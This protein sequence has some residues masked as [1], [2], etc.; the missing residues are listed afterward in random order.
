MHVRDRA[1]DARLPCLGA[2][3]DLDAAHAFAPKLV[4]DRQAALSAADDDDVVVDAGAR[5]H[6]VRRIAP[7]PALRVARLCFESRGRV[8]TGRNGG[9]GLRRGLCQARRSAE[10]ADGN[11]GCAAEESA[12]VDPARGLELGAV[13]SGRVVFLD[14]F[15]HVFPREL[16]CLEHVCLI[17]EAV[18]REPAGT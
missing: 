15:R 6:P 2:V 18:H 13:L 14:A 11:G 3:D 16:V 5:A 1:P 9:S 10:A 8:G 17:R 4:G 12:P 7:D